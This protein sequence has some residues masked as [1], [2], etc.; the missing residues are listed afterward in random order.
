MIYFFQLASCV[1]ARRECVQ[2]RHWHGA[3]WGRSDIYAI[4]L[5]RCF[6]ADAPLVVDTYELAFAAWVPVA[7][8]RAETS[9]PMLTAAL[10]AATGV[11]GAQP[12]R[13]QTCAS[14]K[15]NRKTQP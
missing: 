2:L 6:S 3:A 12:L 9:H 7:E 13:E 5:L 11:G 15:K 14:V 4:A 10:D 8:L 1:C